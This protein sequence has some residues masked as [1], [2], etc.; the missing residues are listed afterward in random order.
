MSQHA[1][2]A[3]GQEALGASPAPTMADHLMYRPVWTIA[4]YAD[5]TA[6]ARG[7]A[8]ETVTVEGNVLLNT[9]INTMLSLLA[10]GTGTAFNNANARLGV[11]DSTTATAANRLRP[12][13][14]ASGRG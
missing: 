8:F 9:G 10:G 2:H 7:A 13:R 5:D 11:G 4:K 1:E 14:D 12:N 6:F 3:F